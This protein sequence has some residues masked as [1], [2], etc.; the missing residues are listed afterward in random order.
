MGV[1]SGLFSQSVENS[2]QKGNPS[3]ASAIR[4][5]SEYNGITWVVSFTQKYKRN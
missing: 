2:L 3:S 1:W 4:G 5:D